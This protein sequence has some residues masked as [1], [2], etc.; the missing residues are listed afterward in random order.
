MVT[1]GVLRAWPAAA[2]DGCAIV[3]FRMSLLESVLSLSFLSTAN[4]GAGNFAGRCPQLP[5]F[6]ERIHM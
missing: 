5:C 1:P 6:H 2:H 4:G 3:T